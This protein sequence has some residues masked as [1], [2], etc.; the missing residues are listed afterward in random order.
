METLIPEP[1]IIY[2]PSLATKGR[3]KKRFMKSA[4]DLGKLG[5]HAKIVDCDYPSHKGQLITGFE[6]DLK[7]IDLLVRKLEGESIPRSQIGF[8]G[9]CYGAYLT[10]RYMQSHQDIPFV[11]LAEPYFGSESV[12]P[13]Y[14]I[15]ERMLRKVR[16]RT[17]LPLGKR[18]GIKKSI[19]VSSLADF[20][21]ESI[22]MPHNQIPAFAFVTNYHHFFNRELIK[23]KLAESNIEYSILDVTKPEEEQRQDFSRRAY[24][25]LIRQQP[26]VQREA[27]AQ[28]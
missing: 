26:W 11:I 24:S 18:E 6:E 12:Y 20:T 5:I 28:N 17:V 2:L 19:D 8:M 14:R 3:S 27:I 1:T 13:A 23:R 25:F 7:S 16:L 15:I 21:S 4:E 22:N 9:A 10:L